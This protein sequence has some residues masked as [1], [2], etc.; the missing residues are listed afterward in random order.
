MSD[1]KV[2]EVLEKSLLEGTPGDKK[3]FWKELDDSFTNT[4][5][6]AETTYRTNLYI[7]VVIVIIGIIFIANS[8]VY[9]WLNTSD[10]DKLWSLFSGSIGIVSFVT[11]F[12]VKPQVNITTAIGNLAQLQIAYKAHTL[13][14]ESIFV[15]IEKTRNAGKLDF[16]E[17][18]KVN[19][20]LFKQT[21]EAAEI[22]QKYTEAESED[23]NGNKTDGD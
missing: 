22:I 23:R 2:G 8:I 9:A 11:L 18:E 21:T 15:Y 12:F 1:T 14:F 5:K 7:N 3:A 16:A 17:I 6:S 13:M 19:S 10:S 4:L 20:E